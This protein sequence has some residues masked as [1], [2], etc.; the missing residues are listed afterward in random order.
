MVQ[1]IVAF[2][3]PKNSDVSLS[4]STRSVTNIIK[5]TT[6]DEEFGA[7][8]DFIPLEEFKTPEPRW[9]CPVHN[10]V[11]SQTGVTLSR[12][13]MEMS[14]M[15]EDLEEIESIFTSLQVACKTLSNLVRTASLTGITGLEAGGG[16][17]N[18]Q[19]EEQKKLDV[20]ANDVLKNALK[21]SGQMSTL[22]SEEEDVPVQILRDNRGNPVYSSDVIIESSGR[23]TAVFDPLDGSS[24]IDA[25]IPVGTIFGIFDQAECDLDFDLTSEEQESRCL[26]NTLQK[27]KNLVAAGY[28]LYSSATTFV[29]TL[30]NGVWGF[31]YDER[32]GEFVLTHPDMKIPSRGKIYSFNEANR[33]DWDAPLQNYVTDIQQGL[34]DT[35]SKYSSR[36]IGSM[37]ADVHRTL[38]YGGIFGY[39]ADKKN[40]DGKLRLLYEAAPMS[41]L[42]EQAGGLA[43]TGKN[44]I[45]DIPPTSVHQ[46]VP[47]ILGSR[48]D[49]L[50]LRRYYQESQDVELIAR[51][52]AR[53]TGE[54]NVAPIKVNG[55]KNDDHAP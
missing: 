46:R 45:M 32:I 48:E 34:G 25:G 33:W 29:F 55:G 42:I 17:I 50:E 41:F 2:V 18:V 53:M 23:Y 12:Y 24:N 16:S 39:P 20:I 8:N 5:A 22:A 40:P 47:C 26:R 14:R 37:V 49:V 27:G 30:G 35:K 1:P 11:C 6:L 21:W 51:C 15:N 54:I 43:L 13:M 38:Q 4:L 52:Q 19:G 10:D 7:S 44:R 3:I 36:Y 31:T 28:C 9:Q